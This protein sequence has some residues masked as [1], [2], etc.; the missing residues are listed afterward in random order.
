MKMVLSLIASNVELC[1]VAQL[2][3]LFPIPR[4]REV[5]HDLFSEV[6]CVYSARFY[7]PV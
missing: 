6:E 7:Q 1:K 4:E 2:H 3:P 5:M